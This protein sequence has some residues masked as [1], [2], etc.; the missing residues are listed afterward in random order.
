L[1]YLL[2]DIMKGG[3]VGT[4]VAHTAPER[5]ATN[6]LV[7]FGLTLW[8]SLKRR[9]VLAAF[10]CFISGS[11]E[12]ETINCRASAFMFCCS[13]AILSASCCVSF[14]AIFIA[15]FLCLIPSFIMMPTTGRAMIATMRS[16]WNL[17][18]IR[19]TRS[20]WQPLDSFDADFGRCPATIPDAPGLGAL[21]KL[22]QTNYQ[23]MYTPTRD[24][25]SIGGEQSAGSRRCGCR[26]W[27]IGQSCCHGPVSAV[28]LPRRTCRDITTKQ[29]PA[30]IRADACFVDGYKTVGAEGLWWGARVRSR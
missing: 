30:T 7:T 19:D 1:K 10:F 2:S 25:D 18:G 11:C 16:S 4:A 13:S 15:S 28:V 5:S 24:I 20:I 6:I 26:T 17:I 9:V 27:S 14:Q 29:A 23:I 3:F 8:I 12:R 22:T 21:P